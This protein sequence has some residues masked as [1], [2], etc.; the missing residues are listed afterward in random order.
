MDIW[1]GGRIAVPQEDPAKLGTPAA[2]DSKNPLWGGGRM[3]ESGAMYDQTANSISLPDGMKPQDKM[4]MD[5]PEAQNVGQ[6]I[7]GAIG[8]SATAL[9]IKGAIAKAFGGTTQDILPS[10][11]IG[12]NAPYSQKIPG[13][14]FGL[15]PDLPL[16]MASAAGGTAAGGPL[17][18]LAAMGA[19]PAAMR[20][21]WIDYLATGHLDI[22]SEAW[23]ATKGGVS[24]MAMGKAGEIA[25]INSLVAA[26]IDKLTAKKI[27]GGEVE[28]LAS[29]MA[30]QLMTLP[31]ATKVDA[32]N[33]A[34]QQA[35]RQLGITAEQQA[36]IKGVQTSGV[37]IA[38]NYSAQILGGTAATNLME[39]RMPTVDDFLSQAVMMGGMHFAGA[40]AN[41]LREV[42]ART[43]KTPGEVARDIANRPSIL[44]E[45]FDQE[46]AKKM[47][48][49]QTFRDAERAVDIRARA[50]S[51]AMVT[52]EERL[53][54]ERAE[55]KDPSPVLQ[56]ALELLGKPERTERENEFL[57]Q[58]RTGDYGQMY[59][60]IA[61]PDTV[62]NEAEKKLHEIEA[63]AAETRMASKEVTPEMKAALESAQKDHDQMV[64]FTKSK[65][66]DNPQE[67][68][69]RLRNLE[70]EFAE[71]RRYIMGEMT[72]SEMKKREAIATAN[73]VGKEVLVDEIGRAHV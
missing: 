4:W 68:N 1:S 73:Y 72:S 52:P 7:Q 12:E 43:G 67:M 18:G 71:Q 27:I 51:G 37:N 13:W 40:G 32:I 9:T 61:T 54:L 64:A 60:G 50:E 56:K 8:G 34:M 25:G 21:A 23:E 39:W 38:K 2:F 53:V 36:I 28:K 17:A 62:R 41:K 46:P 24:M 5:I 20:Q 69:A 6:A 35:Y 49:A 10:Y 59:A 66:S 44:T 55:P 33:T 26:G 16:M 29:P 58:V 47:E 30:Q 22:G 15:A 70:R 11:R 45:L 48:E 3:A 63:A 31:G 57:D 42:F 65:F 14:L 19:A